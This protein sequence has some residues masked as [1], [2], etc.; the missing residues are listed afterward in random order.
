MKIAMSVGLFAIQI[1]LFEIGSHTKHLA[2]AAELTVP[3]TPYTSEQNG[4]SDN[5]SSPQSN[6]VAKPP[7][8]NSALKRKVSKKSKKNQKQVERSDGL[9]SVRYFSDVG[10][11]VVKTGYISPLRPYKKTYGYYFSGGYRTVFLDFGVAYSTERRIWRQLEQRPAQEVL[12]EQLE[13]IKSG[14]LQR[15]EY[16]GILNNF[17]WKSGDF[18]TLRMIE[19]YLGVNVYLPQPISWGIIQVQMGILMGELRDEIVGRPRYDLAGLSFAN[20]LSSLLIKNSDIHFTAALKYSIM[21]AST[22]GF[23]DSDE[24][25]SLQSLSLTGGFEYLF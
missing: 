1:L 18:F 7:K 15:N 22:N 17:R 5:I 21:E 23:A 24:Q 25:L 10:R 13:R 6:G 4:A 14:E 12:N 16:S 8:G 9:T 20:T 2:F 3:K 11:F 19:P